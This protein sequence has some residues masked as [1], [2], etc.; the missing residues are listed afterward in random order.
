M[1]TGNQHE[2]MSMARLKQAAKWVKKQI[3]TIKDASYY[4][5]DTKRNDMSK[6]KKEKKE[7]AK[8]E[9]WIHVGEYYRHPNGDIYHVVDVPYNPEDKKCWVQYMKLG[10]NTTLIRNPDSFL[11]KAW[12]DGKHVPRFERVI[13]TKYQTQTDENG[14]EREVPIEFGSADEVK[15]A[16][17]R[18]VD[19]KVTV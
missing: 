9:R 18:M 13:P 3:D 14:I 8:K 12:I 6:N 11:G 7:E 17:K 5:Y 2:G 15:P 16:G 10:S 19:S 1:L 4:E